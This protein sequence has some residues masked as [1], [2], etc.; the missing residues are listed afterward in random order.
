MAV[1]ARTGTRQ[2]LA[3]KAYQ[4]IKEA[5]LRQEIVPGQPLYE[6][7]LA[8]RL[9]ISRTPVRAAIARL[10]REE[11]L[12]RIPN[13]GVIVPPVE[14]KDVHDVFE[15]RE[16]L[17][18]K[19][20]E[21]AFARVDREQ[22][23]RFRNSFERM[24]RDPEVEMADAIRADEEFHMYIAQTGGNRWIIRT[25]EQVLQRTL[26]MRAV[27][28]SRVGRP[29]ETFLEH[30]NLIDLWLKGDLD[31]TTTVLK[32]HI[33]RAKIAVLQMEDEARSYE[34][35]SAGPSHAQQSTE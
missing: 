20:L 9:G 30:I 35:I 27:S 10:E 28:T 24:L 34:L 12:K 2:N 14:L 13:W 11:L 29:Q 22:L 32:E 17:E 8:E 21:K 7:P 1:R 26:M 5:I 15:L 31:A 18:V 4:A 25:L 3:D 16:I 19:A 23:A 6:L 33:L